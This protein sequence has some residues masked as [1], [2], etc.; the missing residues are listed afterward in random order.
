MLRRVL[1]FAAA[2]LGMAFASPLAA[3]VQDWAK[4]P[5][6]VRGDTPCAFAE[7]VM[8]AWLARDQKETP[9]FDDQPFK[10]STIIHWKTKKP[11]DGIPPDLVAKWEAS[12]GTS[13]L[14]ACPAAGRRLTIPF[15]TDQDRELV[16][17]LGYG[18]L[19]VQFSAPFVSESGDHILLEVRFKCPGLCGSGVVL[20][21]RKTKGGW[22]RMPPA[23]RYVS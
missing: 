13:L 8:A 12:P 11:I 1:I 19:L 3:A 22:S 6:M 5:P 20:H 16:Q 9:T 18:P 7:N 14:D 15:A 17:H 2:A 21:Y 4:G 10:G 23:A